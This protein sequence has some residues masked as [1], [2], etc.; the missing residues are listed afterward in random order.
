[1]NLDSLIGAAGRYVFFTGKGGVG[2]TSVSSA[3]ALALADRG[4]RVL[5]VST[6]PA[7][8]LDEVLATPLGSGPRPVNGVDRLW[9]MN[10]DPEAAAAAYRERVVGP[11]R[12]LLPASAVA[13]I[14]EQLSGA[15]TVEIAAF[16]EFTALLTDDELTAGF[17]HV[18]FDT[19]PTGHT[20]RL[21]ALPA[22]WT[23]FIDENTLGT[24]CIGPLSGLSQQQERYARA[25]D[26]LADAATTTLVLVARPDR[27]SLGEAARAARELAELG[28]ADQ[29]L[30][31][32][33][34]FV[35]G[36]PADPVAA[37]L[38]RR[39]REALEALPSELRPLPRHEVPLVGWN[40]VGTAGLRALVGGAAPVEV[41]PAPA[42]TDLR[43]VGLADLV[44]DLDAAGHGLVMTMG[45]GGVG[46]TTLAAAIAVEL[47]RR[48]HRVELSTTDPAAHL[49]AT[50]GS[51]AGVGD[52]VVHRIDPEV[53]TE[54]YTA[55][56]LATTGAGLDDRARAVLEEDLRSP[57][58]AE[59]AVFRAFARTV[60]SATDRFVVLDTAPTGHTMLLLDAARAYHR[61]L[62]RQS[63]AVPSEVSALL[64]RLRDPTFTHL[65]VVT[66]PEPTPVHEAADLQQ[67]L[68]R[69]GIEPEAWIVNRSL[70]VAGSTDP[71]LVRRARDERRW[72]AEVHDTLARRVAVVPWAA[73]PPV[74]PEELGRL[75]GAVH[76]GR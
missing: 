6:D 22:A 42:V 62:G 43:L 50:V 70:T 47:A 28:I 29:H 57:C 66:L 9:A 59:I 67:D 21:L 17:D 34:V 26:T 1:M 15:C 23:A 46:K 68:R 40:P 4:A 55:E 54:A 41:E 19:A 51:H 53:E 12:D 2:K 58:T 48:G 63:G 31:V 16:D 64:D 35:A 20:L 71:V 75:F 76:A 37:G 30:V 65:F 32:N 8:N 11:Y 52:L 45:K 3:L 5:L 39:G 69:A 36:D 56:V 7:S 18:V 27:I 72:I 60:G 24:S 14:E 10:V 33:G 38:E 74:G 44:A 25:V 61:E 13:S 73:E 49:D